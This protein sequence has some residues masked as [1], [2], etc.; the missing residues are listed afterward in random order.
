MRE[1]WLCAKWNLRAIFKSPRMIMCEVMGFLLCFL[2]TDFSITLSHRYQTSLQAFEPFIWCYADGDSI[3]YASLVLML[4]LTGVPRLD[5][6]ASYFIFRID[7]GGWLLG[8]VLTILIVTLCYCL[9]L[10]LS[11]M[12]LGIGQIYFSNHW[13][14]TA[15]L[16]SFSDQRFQT[17]VSVVRKTVK[18]TLPFQSVVNI[19]FLLFQYV[20][21][22]SLLQLALTIWKNKKIGI[23]A[24]ICLHAYGYLLTP[25]RFMAWLSLDET[26][27]YIANLLAA[28]LSPLQ[29]ATYIMHNFG[30]DKL[31]RL[32]T[33]HALLGALSLILLAAAY[34]RMRKFNFQF[35]GGSINGDQ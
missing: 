20:L 11:T 17:A 34:I 33:S 4:L 19:F 29:H 8:Q 3:L 23:L 14:D 28:W 32:W 22:V 6:A 35:A 13:S 27:Q 9:F 16:L 25:D 31:P 18:L 12:L 10:L 5:T 1:I 21:F 24:A 7:R 30:Y 26:H 2:L 15:V